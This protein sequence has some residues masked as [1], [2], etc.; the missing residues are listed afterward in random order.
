[1][2]ELR[3]S[4]QEHTL[5]AKAPFFL[6][7]VRPKAEALGYLEARD[8]LASREM[9]MMR[10]TVMNGTPGSCA[11]GGSWIGGQLTHHS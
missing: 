5:G 6:R 11:D 10:N 3:W 4:E 7:S 8:G 9:F 2:T 1:M